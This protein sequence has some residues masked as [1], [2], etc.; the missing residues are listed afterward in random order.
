M[1][2]SKGDETQVE[3]NLDSHAEKPKRGGCMGFCKKWWWAILIV[4]GAVILIVILPL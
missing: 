3:H 1:S 4:T 2:L